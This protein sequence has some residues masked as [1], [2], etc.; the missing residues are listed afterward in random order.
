MLPP[1]CI[2]IQNGPGEVRVEEIEVYID[3][4]NVLV[5]LKTS[6]DDVFSQAL[7]GYVEGMCHVQRLKDILL[8]DL[9]EGTTTAFY[10]RRRVFYYHELFQ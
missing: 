9:S 3:T 1:F 7:G 10:Q 6:H 2:N 5:R 4:P 8:N